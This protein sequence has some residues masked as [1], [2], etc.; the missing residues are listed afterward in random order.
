ML[1][2][3]RATMVAAAGSADTKNRNHDNIDSRVF[4]DPL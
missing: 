3:G 1:R 2:Y 4:A